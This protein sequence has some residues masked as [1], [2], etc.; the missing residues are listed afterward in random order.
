MG[1]GVSTGPAYSSPI[2]CGFAGNHDAENRFASRLEYYD[3]VKLLTT[4]Q[5]ETVQ[6]EELGAVAHGQSFPQR[7]VVDNIALAYPCPGRFNIGL[8]HTA[9]DGNEGHASRATRQPWLSILGSGPCS[10]KRSAAA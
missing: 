5:P 9:C 8:L 1:N 10:E 3:N 7:D 4:R 6:I 2:A